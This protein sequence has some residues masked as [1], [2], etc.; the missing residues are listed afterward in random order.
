MFVFVVVLQAFA[1]PPEAR[2]RVVGWAIGGALALRG[3]F[4]LAGAALLAAADWTAYVFA[5][6]LRPGGA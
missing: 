3:G 5:A 2:R 1:V 6:F 4:I